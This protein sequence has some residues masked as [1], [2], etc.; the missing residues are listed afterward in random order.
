MVHFSDPSAPPSSWIYSVQHQ[1]TLCCPCEKLLTVLHPRV[2]SCSHHFLSMAPGTSLSQIP[3][4]GVLGH[5][6]VLRPHSPLDLCMSCCLGRLTLPL[7]GIPFSCPSRWSIQSNFSTHQRMTL[8]SNDLCEDTLYISP[9]STFIEVAVPRKPSTRSHMETPSVPACCLTWLP[10]LPCSTRCRCRSSRYVKAILFP[11]VLQ[12]SATKPQCSH[13]H[14]PASPCHCPGCPPAGS[15]PS[16]AFSSKQCIPTPPCLSSHPISHFSSFP[17]DVFSALPP[18]VRGNWGT[19]WITVL[20]K[21]N[22]FLALTR[23]SFFSLNN[24]TLH[25]FTFVH[26]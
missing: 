21:E 6:A 16:Q 17:L 23:K 14:T 22:T 10:A 26:F 2:S 19:T 12:A 7:I 24:T 8:F 4:P 20:P 1:W 25:H 11:L 13:P 5:C 9:K 15:A 3:F 18:S